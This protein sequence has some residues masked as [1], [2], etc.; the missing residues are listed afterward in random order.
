MLGKQKIIGGNIFSPKFSGLPMWPPLGTS[1]IENHPNS[2]FRYGW[3]KLE[4]LVQTPN[5]YSEVQR[6]NMT[7]FVPNSLQ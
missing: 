3:N 6:K 4:P 1:P 7:F 2:I 5:R